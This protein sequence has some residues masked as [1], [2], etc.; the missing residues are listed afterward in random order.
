LLTGLLQRRSSGE[1]EP[2]EGVPT[3]TPVLRADAFFVGE[4]FDCLEMPCDD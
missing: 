4:F 2:D 1:V 3:N